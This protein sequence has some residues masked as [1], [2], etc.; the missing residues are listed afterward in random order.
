MP[1]AIFLQMGSWR[2]TVAACGGEGGCLTPL[3]E[4]LNSTCCYHIRSLK[5][6]NPHVMSDERSTFQ[7]VDMRDTDAGTE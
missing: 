2:G 3:E 6:D 5:R 7:T 1:T 4:Y